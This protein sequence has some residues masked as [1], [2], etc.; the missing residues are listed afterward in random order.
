MAEPD[1]RSL[2]DPARRPGRWPAV[3]LLLLIAAALAA[4]VLLGDRLSFQALSEHREMLISLRDA[5]YPAAAAGFIAIYAALVALSLPGALIATLAGGFLF[6]LF[7]GALFS[8][9]GATLGAVV[10]FLAVRAG[11]G[12]AL[13]RRLA[14]GGGAPAR[15]SAALRENELSVLF[16]MRLLPVVPF[17]V[18][19]LIPAMLGVSLGRFVITTFFGIMPGGLVYTWVGA[20]LGEVFAAGGKPDLGLLFEPQILGPILA[21]A[22]LA[23]LPI[24]VRAFGRRGR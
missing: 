17:F 20:G 3:P 9:T 8:V 15:L 14:T 2:A 19:N 18:A 6:G 10:V 7:P 4:A 23:A 5:N 13:A 24:A 12:A 21:L 22:A 11:F 1:P 16:L